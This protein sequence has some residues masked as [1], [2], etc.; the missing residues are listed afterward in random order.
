MKIGNAKSNNR[1]IEEDT[2]EKTKQERKWG[3]KRSRES[4]IDGQKKPV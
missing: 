3:K 4:L 1:A 2:K